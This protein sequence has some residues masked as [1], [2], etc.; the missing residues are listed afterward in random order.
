M[1]HK[2]NK[3]LEE[4]AKKAKPMSDAEKQAKMEAVKGMDDLASSMMGDKLHSLKKVSVA[5]PDE[6]GLA[7]GLDVA[8]GMVEQHKMGKDLDAESPSEEHDRMQEGEEGSPE[9]EASESPAEEAQ[10]DREYSHKRIPM[11]EEQVPD[12]SPEE[13]QKELEGSSDHEDEIAQLEK[14]L[15][16]LKSKRG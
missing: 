9:E 14:R 8:K 7:E 1:L 11:D 16:H 12:E 6:E 13:E 2:L 4:K 3:L 15:A 5:S 10:E